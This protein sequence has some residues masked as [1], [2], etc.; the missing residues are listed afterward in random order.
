MSPR[1]RR[2]LE[3][4]AIAAF[5]LISTIAVARIGL[6]PHDMSRGV[7][8]V[9]SPWTDE[10]AAFA[11]A[12]GSGARF[13]RFGGLPFVVIVQPEVADYARRVKEAGALL[14][15]D[16]QVLAACFSWTSSDQVKK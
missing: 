4:T 2:I 6:E 16:P 10:N 5:A 1:W 8:V 14:L 11:R 13:V 3:G 9:F 7:G 12:V 15:L